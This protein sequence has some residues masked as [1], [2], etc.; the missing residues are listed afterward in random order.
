MAYF[1]NV[2]GDTLVQPLASDGSEI[3]YPPVTAKVC[4]IT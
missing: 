1:V 3:K 4:S 2:N